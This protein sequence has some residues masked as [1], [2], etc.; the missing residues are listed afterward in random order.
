MQIGLDSANA[1]NLIPAAEVEAEAA[2]RREAFRQDTLKAWADH[3]ATGPHAT[4]EE[5]DAWLASLG[6]DNELPP[7]AGH[8]RASARRAQG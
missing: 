6:T 8:Q 2:A 4:A 3:Q 5:V 7:P 1:G